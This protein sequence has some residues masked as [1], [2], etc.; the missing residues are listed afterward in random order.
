MNTTPQKTF[1][2]SVCSGTRY[3]AVILLTTFLFSLLFAGHTLQ[4]PWFYD[5]YHT[6]RPFSIAEIV[7]TL[8]GNWDVTGLE[9]ATYR[10]LS[11][12]TI[13]IRCFF[14]GENMEQHRLFLLFALS[15]FYSL[16]GY[17]FLITGLRLPFV[18]GATCFTVI[19]KS[20][21]VH[22]LMLI[23]AQHAISGIPIACCCIIAA[24]NR[25][26]WGTLKKVS[27]FL[28]SIT[29]L[30]IR[31]TSMVL[32]PLIIFFAILSRNLELEKI[33]KYEGD[34]FFKAISICKIGIG[35]STPLIISSL[36]YIIAR[37]LLVPEAISN[38]IILGILSHIKMTIFPMGFKSYKLILYSWVFF[39]FCITINLFFYSKPTII[40]ITK[41][42]LLIF[43]IFIS[44]ILG[45]MVVRCDLVMVPA[46][47]FSF[48]LAFTIQRILDDK[49]NTPSFFVLLVVLFFF[50]IT[51][52]ESRKSLLGAHPQSYQTMISA[53]MFIYGDYASR[54][55][56][57]PERKKKGMAYLHTYGI[58]SDVDLQT[59]RGD[60][61]KSAEKN[62]N[63]PPAGGGL[64]IPPSWVLEM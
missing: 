20:T 11:A 6:V 42:L 3:F 26:G 39:L 23:A 57:P 30:C 62:G 43:C 21:H 61:M 49:K 7:Q 58:D 52:Q 46:M 34:V 29:G 63:F 13:S 14:F 17:A 59:K 60:L 8:H 22:I 33:F 5:D 38:I 51:W 37:S 47:I 40:F 64:F 25:D 44:C 12:L 28:L 55:V 2:A 53:G 54:A 4:Y 36:I 16:I 24:S 32:F 48:L 1:P 35:V 50:S 15:L 18:V 31:E 27:I 41:I 10:P 45:I 19:A 9:N 56:I